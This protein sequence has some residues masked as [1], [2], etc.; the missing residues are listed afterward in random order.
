MPVGNARFHQSVQLT[1]LSVEF[2]VRAVDEELDGEE[3]SN[4]FHHVVRSI[5]DGHDSRV[6]VRLLLAH[7]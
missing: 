3:P 7:V 2:D 6:D 5:G 1:I 4:D